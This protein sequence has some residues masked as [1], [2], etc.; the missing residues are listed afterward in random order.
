MGEAAAVGTARAVG[1]EAVDVVVKYIV[2]IGAAVGGF[3]AGTK[4]LGGSTLV[5]LMAI[6]PQTGVNTVTSTR[7]IG[8][9]LALVSALIGWA[10]W[11]LRSRAGWIAKLI[12][13]GVGGFFL[14]TAAGYFV[15]CTIGGNSPSWGFLD[16]IQAWFQ[17]VASG[18]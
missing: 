7:I 16:T 10:F 1:T 6:I 18:S 4:V 15:G 9:L 5:G 17:G 13:G 11:H 12:G 14:G 8:A 3:V 2:P